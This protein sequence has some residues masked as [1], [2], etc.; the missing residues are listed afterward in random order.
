MRKV[1]QREADFEAGPE[2]WGT[3]RGRRVKSSG[4][5][6]SQRGGGRRGSVSGSGVNWG[7]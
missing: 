7:R 6:V 2:G 3:A 5:R 1:Y 4:H